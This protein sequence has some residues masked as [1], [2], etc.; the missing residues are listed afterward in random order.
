MKPTFFILTAILF[1]CS[2]N[3]KHAGEQVMD[4]DLGNQMLLAGNT[5]TIDSI[6]SKIIDSLTLLK[7]TLNRSSVIKVYF[8]SIYKE[9]KPLKTHIAL[10]DTSQNG[11][12]NSKSCIV[13]D[14][15]YYDTHTELNEIFVIGDFNFDGYEDFSVLNWVSINRQVS[16]DFY[17]FNVKTKKYLFNKQLTDLIN[18]YFDHKIKTV[19]SCWN[20]G[21]N[22]FGHA[23]FNWRIDSLK[24]IARETLI[25]SINPDEE[26]EIWLEFYEDNKLQTKSYI[27]TGDT[28]DYLHDTCKLMQYAK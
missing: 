11:I 7:Y 6:D 27:Y 22:E 20:I 10:I 16:Y 4:A 25:Y 8:D 19:H 17:V 13:S 14:D 3:C 21:V 18:P 1:I 12:F 15:Y 9:G 23:L 5:K 26:P 2:V 24:L 28:F